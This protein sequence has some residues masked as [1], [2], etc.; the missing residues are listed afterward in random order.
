MKTEPNILEYEEAAKEAEVAR[1][2]KYASLLYRQPFSCLSLTFSTVGYGD[3]TPV[4]LTRLVAMLEVL[5]AIFIVP[6]FI[7]GLSRKYLRI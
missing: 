6:L 3:I 5:S 4:G 2:L 1:D 7:V